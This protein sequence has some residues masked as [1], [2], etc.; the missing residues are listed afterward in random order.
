MKTAIILILVVA[1]AALGLG[2]A[3]LVTHD[4]WKATTTVTVGP[5]QPHVSNDVRFDAAQH[6]VTI[7]VM[8]ERL[9]VARQFCDLLRDVGHPE[10]GTVC[11]FNVENGD[12]WYDSM[13]PRQIREV[14]EALVAASQ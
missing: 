11:R 12:P 2:G 6:G 13:P 7:E 10:V 14:A 8:Q 9:R 3:V 4:Y 5:P 1:L